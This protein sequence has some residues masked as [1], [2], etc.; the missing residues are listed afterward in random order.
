VVM[1][2]SRM[3]LVSV[4]LIASLALLFPNVHAQTTRI[5]ELRHPSQVLAGG[6]EPFSVQAVISFQDSK[7]NSSL[8]IGILDI[9][10]RPQRIIPGI[11]TTA[12]PDQCVNQQVLQALCVLKV[13]ASS[14]VENLEFKIGGILG[15][16]PLRLGTWDLN[17]TA[18]LLDSNNALIGKSVSSM[19]F[20]VDLAPLS[21]T[22][23]VPAHVTVIVDGVKQP[24]GS[25]TLGVVAGSHNISVS[26]TADVD[27]GTR[28]KFHGWSDGFTE[29]SRAINVRAAS[30]FE[31]TYDT[32][33]KLSL[34][35]E[36]GAATG[37]GWYDAG[38]T[39]TFSISQVQLMSG[40]L[41][42]L[43]GKMTFQGWYENGKSLTSSPSGS[44]VMSQP[45]TLTVFWQA[46]YSRPI[47]IV[48]ILVTVV[49]LVLAL[50][51][52]KRADFGKPNETR[53]VQ[54]LIESQAQGAGL[55]KGHARGVPSRLRR[56]K[57]SIHRRRRS[58]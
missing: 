24:P 26:P 32:Q 30:D 16:Q 38:S 57:P 36:Q 39:A 8:A 10:S 29:L 7:T 1:N 27:S 13:R 5:V 49:A 56:P 43:G 50:T 55:S 54:S 48:S 11:V 2:S 19:P 53:L 58:R 47:A 45:H 18:G 15:G 21:L 17:I 31:A 42:L 6:L 51:I 46:D 35:S 14:G 20:G 9:G 4:L 33:Y 23:N 41:G 12:Y 37:Q 52:R 44:I 22:V 3:L 40:L 25:V 34:I 28:L